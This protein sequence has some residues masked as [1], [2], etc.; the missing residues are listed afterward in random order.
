MDDLPP[1]LVVDDEMIVRLALV[2]ALQEG[3]YTVL[4]AE[5]G[6]TALDVIAKSEKLRALVTDIR[7]P[8]ADGWQIAHNARQKFASLPVVYVSGDSAADW[9]ANGVPMSLVLQK[10][11]ASA[12]LVT[13]LATLLVTQQRP[14]QL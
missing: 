3:G 14:A 5:D 13:A 10:P 9:A 4:E 7:L 8:G 6:N 2:D 11:F 12:E 1:I